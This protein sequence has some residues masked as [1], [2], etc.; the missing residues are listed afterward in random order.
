MAHRSIGDVQRRRPEP[1]WGWS[2]VTAGCRLDPNGARVAA[3][4]ALLPKTRT[5]PEDIVQRLFELGA[6]YHG[7]LHQDEFGPARAARSAALRVVEKA[8]DI[9]LRRLAKLPQRFESL[10]RLRLAEADMSAD[11]HR[12]DHWATFELERQSLETVFDAV[13]SMKDESWPN[14]RSAAARLRRLRHA[15]ER[16]LGLFDL[17]DTTSAGEVLLAFAGFD[18]NHIPPVPSAGDAY[19]TICARLARLRARVSTAREALSSR[20]GP[21]ERTS[22]RLLVEQLCRLWLAETGTMV[23]SSA[24]VSGKYTG[25]PQSPAG[26]FIAAT[27]EALLPSKAWLEE[28]ASKTATAPTKIIMMSQAGRATAINTMLADYVARHPGPERRGRR[29]T[30]VQTI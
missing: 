28:H 6:R 29:K 14:S 23:T 18:P 22:L 11:A 24:A 21:H 15:A 30:A 4:V 2:G 8:L 20:R 13:S 9:L 10:V 12:A 25:S 17:L 19:T 27:V 16:A 1:R 26:R 7:N 3:A 5:E